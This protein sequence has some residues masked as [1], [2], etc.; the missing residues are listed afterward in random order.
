M[1]K[2]DKRYKFGRFFKRFQ[3]RVLFLFV[4][5]VRT[6]YDIDLVCPVGGIKLNV[7]KAFAQFFDGQ[8]RVDAQKVKVHSRR[9]FF[10]GKTFAARFFF[11]VRNAET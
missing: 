5:P 8:R 10:A 9:N 7:V 1:R 2:Q 11:T 6:V 3:K 4:Q